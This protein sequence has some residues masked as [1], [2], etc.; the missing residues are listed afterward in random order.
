ME[1][2]HLSIRQRHVIM[3]GCEEEE[4]SGGRKCTRCGRS[5]FRANP[6]TSAGLFPRLTTYKYTVS[7][8]RYL[9][10]ATFRG[11]SEGK[12]EVQ[13]QIFVGKDG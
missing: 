12:K 10:G 7:W 13:L 6:K 2:L 9:G 8:N 5:F 11:L 4:E 1:I 3:L